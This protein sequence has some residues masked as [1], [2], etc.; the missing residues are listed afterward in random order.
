MA[1]YYAPNFIFLVV[2]FFVVASPSVLL[3]VMHTYAYF[4]CFVSDA[5]LQSLRGR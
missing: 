2:V 1:R 5:V 3:F 4:T